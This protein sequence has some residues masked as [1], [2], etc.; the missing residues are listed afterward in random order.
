MIKKEFLNLVP[1][2]H[3]QPKFD[4]LT[5]KSEIEILHQSLCQLEKDKL[6]ILYPKLKDHNVEGLKD[7]IPHNR[8]K[9]IPTKIT[10]KE[11]WFHKKILSK[12]KTNS[13]LAWQ[14][15]L[16]NVYVY[17]HLVPKMLAT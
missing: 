11:S 10:R 2:F 17:V 9:K 13:Q 8:N 5:K 15:L 6:L 12:T 7:H 16:K 3:L 4:L 14:P 1:N